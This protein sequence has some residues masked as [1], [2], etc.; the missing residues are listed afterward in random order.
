MRLNDHPAFQNLSVGEKIQVKKYVRGVLYPQHEG[1]WEQSWEAL[2]NLYPEI[3]GILN[4][5]DRV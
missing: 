2:N 1:E 3:Y 5:L 4:E